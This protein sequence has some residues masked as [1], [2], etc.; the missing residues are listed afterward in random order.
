MSHLRVP[1]FPLFDAGGKRHRLGLGLVSWSRA[2]ILSS[3]S[4]S[5]GADRGRGLHEMSS[6]WTT[7]QPSFLKS[8]RH[9]RRSTRRWSTPAKVGCGVRRSPS[10]RSRMTLTAC[11]CPRSSSY[12]VSRRRRLAATIRRGARRHRSPR[13][14]TSIPAVTSS[15]RRG[16]EHAGDPPMP[17]RHRW[18]CRTIFPSASGPRKARSRRAR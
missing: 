16:S 18:M 7:N 14:P 6:V 15:A 2:S 10:R 1:S 4:I 13:S 17:P 9:W 11:E 8:G 12:R 5:A 3:T